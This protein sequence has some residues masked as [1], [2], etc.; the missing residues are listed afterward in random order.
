MAPTFG[1]ANSDLR[2]TVEIG[3]SGL[4]QFGGRISEEWLRKL[5]GQRAAEIFREMADNDYTVGAVLFLIEMLLRGV[6]WRVERFDDRPISHQRAAY[7]ESLLGDMAHSFEDFIAEA[8]SFLEQGYSPHEIVYKRRFGP[9]VEHPAWQSKHSDGLWGWRKL[10]IRAQTTI[11][12]WDFDDAGELRGLFQRDLYNG[13]RRTGEVYIPAERLL[14]FRT[15]SRRGNPEGVSILR[16]CYRA[17]YFK[18]HIEESEAIGVERD[19]CGIPAWRL[20]PR[21]FRP[22]AT[23]EEKAELQAYLKVS[24]NLKQD[25]QASLAYPAEYDANGNKLVELTLLGT[26]AK[27]LF[28][29]TAIIQRLDRAIAGTVL[30]DFLQLGRDKVGSFALSSDKTDMFVLACRAWLYA[31]A[32]PLNREGLPRLFKLNGWPTNECPQFIPGDIEKADVEKFAQAV[33]SLTQAGQLTPG[34]KATESAIRDMLDLPEE[35]VVNIRTDQPGAPG[36]G[37]PAALDAEARVAEM[38]TGPKP[39]GP[40]QPQSPPDVKPEPAGSP[41]PPETVNPD[42]ALNGAQVVALM[43]IVQQVALGALPRA[44]GVELIRACFPLTL[45]QA[46]AIMGEVGRTFKPA[47]VPGAAPPGP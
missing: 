47:P 10:A 8:L 13:T 1:S 35:D 12:R 14:I 30:A 39:T 19:L 5:Q 38:L 31:I 4:K 28:D 46:E 36:A 40:V 44:S 34:G 42:A 24:R 29:T 21:L 15:T 23:A 2:P 22:D 11:D 6:P 41:V 17:W 43:G 27:R 33:A 3:S 16:R 32:A 18:T 26:G 9:N 25:E 7:V 37:D 45:T 20:P